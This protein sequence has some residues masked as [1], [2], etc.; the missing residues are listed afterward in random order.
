MGETVIGFRAI[1]LPVEECGGVNEVQVML[2]LVKVADDSHRMYME[3]LR[4]EN[5]KK[6]W[7][8]SEN[9]EQDIQK[10]T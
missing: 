7:K 2:D 3:G 8:E 1:K 6:G 10:E 4:L 9:P 5:T